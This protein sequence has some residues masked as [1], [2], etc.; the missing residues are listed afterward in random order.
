MKIVRRK[1]VSGF[2][3]LLSAFALLNLVIATV[4]QDFG[5][6]LVT[7]LATL[8]GPMTGA[9]SRGLQRCCLQFSLQLL[10]YFLPFPAAAFLAA[11]LA[12]PGAET[13]SMQRFRFSLWIAA[14]FAWFCGGLFSFGHAL[15]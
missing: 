10:P 7:A 13:A 5:R 4:N 2:L 1:Y 6:G 11:L 3:Q 8:L 9:I 14:W 12:N 15:S